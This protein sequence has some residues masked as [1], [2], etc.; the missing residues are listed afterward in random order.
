[1]WEFQDYMAGPGT[2]ASPHLPVSGC[3][4]LTCLAG[5]RAD[6]SGTVYQREGVAATLVVGD[7]LMKGRE[8]AWFVGVQV[9]A[10][11]G[12]GT[13]HGVVQW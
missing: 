7:Q 2:M 8:L 5:R 9:G 13:G 11:V 12:V 1:M 3:R 6:H 10:Q 4:L